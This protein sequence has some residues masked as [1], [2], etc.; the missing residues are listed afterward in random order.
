MSSLFT[1]F[2]SFFFLFLAY[3]C[4]LLQP[5]GRL[6]DSV[7]M[8]S[9]FDRAFVVPG[10]I[11]NKPTEM[12]GDK[13]V[14]TLRRRP[15]FV[16]ELHFSVT[17]SDSATL[18]T[19]S[20]N[21]KRRSRPVNQWEITIWRIFAIMRNS[22]VATITTTLPSSIVYPL[23]LA[24]SDFWT[25]RQNAVACTKCKRNASN[26]ISSILR[27]LLNTYTYPLMKAVAALRK[28]TR[29]FGYW[30]AILRQASVLCSISWNHSF[31]LAVSLPCAPRL[32]VTRKIKQERSSFNFHG[33][34]KLRYIT[35]VFGCITVRNS[36]RI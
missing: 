14:K 20:A 27:L 25:G 8:W 16:R 35:F 34:T 4:I 17:L 21:Q 1:A 30:A 24:T 18:T 6:F 36:W 19:F 31:P 15:S 26:R 12:W 23:K 11:T 2:L 32:F 10:C 3:C 29:R 7:P 9:L 28:F 33:V 13:D 5:Q 22:I